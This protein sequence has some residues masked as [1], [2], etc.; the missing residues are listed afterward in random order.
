MRPDVKEAK[1][2]VD[3]Y[4]VT[5]LTQ[6]GLVSTRLN[7]FDQALKAQIGETAR[8]NNQLYKA[9]VPDWKTN[10]VEIYWNGRY[11]ENRSPFAHVVN[12]ELEEQYKRDI[13][14]RKYTGF[15]KSDS[16]DSED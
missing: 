8:A 2:L 11:L 1:R 5:I 13:T 7:L 3:G 14:H 10:G 16:E 4:E 12:F 15:V 6:H 9:S